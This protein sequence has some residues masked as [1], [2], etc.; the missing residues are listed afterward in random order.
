MAAYAAPVLSYV[1]VVKNFNGRANANFISY[2][3]PTGDNGF[4]MGTGFFELHHDFV[5]E[6][7]DNFLRG[8]LRS[9]QITVG[10][11][12]DSIDAFETV[13]TTVNRVGDGKFSLYRT[14]DDY[15]YYRTE[16]D[17][18][19]HRVQRTAS[20]S[21]SIE[22]VGVR[23]DGAPTSVVHT[24]AMHQ[25]GHYFVTFVTVKQPWYEYVDE[26]TDIY[27]DTPTG[28]VVCGRERNLSRIVHKGERHAFYTHQRHTGE[29]ENQTGNPVARL[30]YDAGY[31][32]ENERFIFDNPTLW[33]NVFFHG[34]QI[35]QNATLDYNYDLVFLEQRWTDVPD[36]GPEAVPEPGSIALLLLGLAG[37]GIAR[38]SATA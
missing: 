1:E 10:S 17:E 21:I 24:Q 35:L 2:P 36:P 28:R 14:D 37:L 11:T 16:V 38:K 32:K 30:D 12:D 4:S 19:I 9:A 13:S 20:E 22:A 6:R 33:F 18:N 5:F 29:R 3:N 25:E 23:A 31:L 8:A 7:P 34:D 27:C 26:Y 15:D